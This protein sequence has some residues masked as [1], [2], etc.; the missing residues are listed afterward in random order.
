[1]NLPAPQPTAPE[2]YTF[3]FQGDSITDGNRSRDQDWNHVLGHGYVYLIASRLWYDHPDRQWQFINRGISGN[4]VTD[5]AMRW[6]QDTIDLIPQL[7]T[8]LIGVNDV[9]SMF[10]REN[11]VTPDVFREV[12]GGLLDRTRQQLPGTRI[13][14][15]EPFLLPVGKVKD[16][17]EDWAAEMNRRQQIVRELALKFNALFIPLQEEFNKA[18]R[19]ARPDHWIW[20]GIHPMPGGHELIARMWLR[21]MKK[22][23]INDSDV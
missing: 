6:Q 10:T 7:L 15:C 22:N 20:D 3:L 11:V 13:V 18:C 17:W 8:I 12:Y 14:L 23:S 2:G 16:N 9:A 19:K 5:L 4:K 21:E 1:M